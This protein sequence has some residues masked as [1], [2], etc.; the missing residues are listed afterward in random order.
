MKKNAFETEYKAYNKLAG[1]YRKAADNGDQAG[2]S[3]AR[4]GY[5]AWEQ[6][7]NAK[8]EAYGKVYRLYAEAQE[9]GNTYIDL[10]DCIWD[11]DVASLIDSLRT[12]GIEK[13]TFSSGWSSAVETAW[14]FTQQGCR[15]EG[16]VELNSQHKK[17]MTDEYEKAHGYL[18]SVN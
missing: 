8:G 3:K 2:V 6:E 15:V 5:K 12:Y 16:L 10:H 7:L 14:L 18:F 11:K 4:A 9:V 13:F 1:Q 17:I